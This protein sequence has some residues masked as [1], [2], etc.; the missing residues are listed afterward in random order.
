MT[1]KNMSKNER[2]RR[3]LQREGDLLKQR[4]LDS[5]LEL[6]EWEGGLPHDEEVLVAKKSD[7]IEEAEEVEPVEKFMDEVPLASHGAQGGAVTFDQH[8][9][10]VSARQKARKIQDEAYT[11]TE[12][13]DNIIY[14]PMLEPQEKG[15]FI[16]QAGKD[17]SDRVTAIMESPTDMFKEKQV[18]VLEIEALLAKDARQM[19]FV[20]KN[21]GKL[22]YPKKDFVRKSLLEAAEAIEKGG[23]EAEKALETLPELRVEARKL[24]I[25]KGMD[26]GG[27][28]GIVIQKDAD[29]DWRWV[30][31]PSNNF[32]DRSG[33]IL[34]EMAHKEYVEYWNASR[35][36]QKLPVFTSMHAPGTVRKSAVDFVGYE[37]GFLVMSGKLTENEAAGLLRVQ[38]DYDLGMSHTGWA[39]RGNQDD[40]R[41]IT[42]YRLFEV[43]DLPVSMA[44]NPFAEVSVIS[45]EVVMSKQQ[46]QEQ[47]D[48][49][50]K[51]TGDEDL[52]KMALSEKT[53]L[54]QAQLQE[55]GVE[56]KEAKD[57]S[58]EAPKSETP[59]LNFEAI[60][61]ELGLDE[62]SAVIADLQKSAEIVPI[63][64]SVIKKQAAVI[65]KM[66]AS[67]DEKLE[68]LL[69]PEAGKR[70][71]W[72]DKARESESDG[73]VAEDTELEELKKNEPGPDYADNWLSEATGTEPVIEK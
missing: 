63:L 3:R 45:Q 66:D 28:S 67:Q 32:V 43:T 10:Q 59:K 35:D 11:V 72:M 57:E 56:Q 39:I 1:D 36:E 68:D 54:K 8:D 6:K 4:E 14:N 40:A 2:R 46:E 71:S 37:N 17:F 30:G 25:S 29:G 5:S 13:V 70:F 19:G 21:A 47:L 64:E 26:E 52:A 42:K 24:G 31:W 50:I 18:E 41:Q 51:L 16:S 15:T 49:L 44:D 53:S 73:N 9:E 61:K 20:E 48:Y 7:H 12:L 23:D 34:T 65:E 58:K 69:T 55:A 62:L 60:A 27:K 22:L 33:D 38:K